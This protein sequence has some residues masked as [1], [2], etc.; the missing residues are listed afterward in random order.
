MKPLREY[1]RCRVMWAPVLLLMSLSQPGLAQEPA[2]VETG[3]VERV[4]MGA[5]LPLNGSVFSRNDVAVTAAVAGELDWV[6]EPGTRLAAGESIARLDQAPLRL[7]R[8]E[9]QGLLEREAV[10][11][12]YHGKVVDRYAA[13]SEAQNLS[14]FLLDEALSRR[15]IARKDMAILEARI[16]QLDDEIDRSE[17]RAR[18]PGVLVEREKLGGEYVVPGEIIGRF[19]DMDRLEVRVDVP[20]RY[21]ARV[22]QGDRLDVVA[23]DRVH[24]GVVRTRIAAGDPVS[25]TFELRIDLP[26]ANSDS[27]MPG[28][29][30][31]VE[32][33]LADSSMTLAVPRDAVVIRSE[34]SYVYRVSEGDI[35]ERISV[36]VGAGDASLVAVEGELAEGQ[37]IVVR[38]ADRL[39]HG[40]AVEEPQ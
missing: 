37:R 40:Q 7:R 2:V 39:Q 23:G 31:K 20:I 3:R 10:N 34:G 38:G 13:L 17:V 8:E 6:A 18:F 5:R 4:A 12:A 30:V 19:V 25:Q 16:R 29:L 36:V 15:D 22:A 14:V 35:A 24:P 21:R 1:C 27:I 26:S 33:P 32:I 9:L 28:Q 11:A